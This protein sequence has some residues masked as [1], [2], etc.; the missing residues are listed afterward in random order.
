MKRMF[1]RVTA[2]ARAIREALEGA[3]AI[4]MALIFIP[5]LGMVGLATDIGFVVDKH[6]QM[7]LAADA[8]AY[9]AA[10]AISTNI[11]TNN[12]PTSQPRRTG[13][14]AGPGHAR[15]GGMSGLDW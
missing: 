15:F 11:S 2:L 3:V 9:S 4:H 13:S 5:M 10:I 7:Q 6:R 1:T 8:A 14:Q 12:L